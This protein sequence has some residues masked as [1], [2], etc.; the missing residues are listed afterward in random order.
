MLPSSVRPSIGY[1]LDE[2]RRHRQIKR[3]F[4]AR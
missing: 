1:G 3:R 2:H 4:D